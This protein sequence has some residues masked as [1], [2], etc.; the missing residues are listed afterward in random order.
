[1]K[2]KAIAASALATMALFGASKQAEAGAVLIPYVQAGGGWFTV[3]TYIAGNPASF[4]TAPPPNKGWLHI[5]YQMKD[6]LTRLGSSCTHYDGY[7]ESSITDVTSCLITGSP[8]AHTGALFNDV[9]YGLLPD[10]PCFNY[11][12]SGAGFVVIDDQN[13]GVNNAAIAAEAVVFNAAAGFLYSQ[14]A[15]EMN[16]DATGV[17][18]ELYHLNTL[19]NTLRA[20]DSSAGK[21]IK[22][23]HLYVNGVDNHGA[24]AAYFH[25]FPGASPPL[26]GNPVVT[27]WLYVIPVN[28]KG[29]DGKAT[30]GE[31]ATSL[32]MIDVNYNATIRVR[33]VRDAFDNWL[34][35]FYDRVER[36]QSQLQP[37][38][39]TCV[40]LISLDRLFTAPG[41]SDLSRNGG[42]FNVELERV[43]SGN[44]E[45]GDAAI[46]YKVERATGFGFA[47]T[48]L[49]PQ[50]YIR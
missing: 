28:L 48:P 24:T 3:L 43:I 1:M 4:G 42:W 36:S 22:E 34:P 23:T 11:P 38:D 8:P 32:N 35:G 39:V 21:N 45:V 18:N 15:I 19:T 41:W 16:H 9:D 6:D 31:A 47:V 46:I 14:R 12:V 50:I 33:A 40:G 26:P 37:Q 29:T 17:V 20:F 5:T 10:G 27:T 7:V 2:K 49:T 13:K 25:V 30:K 44:E